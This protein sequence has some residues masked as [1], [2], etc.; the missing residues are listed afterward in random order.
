MCTYVYCTLH[1]S[2]PV[3]EWLLEDF[4]IGQLFATHGGQLMMLNFLETDF[5][6]WDVLHGTGIFTYWFNHK[7][8][9]K[10]VESPMESQK[11]WVFKLTDIFSAH[12]LKLRSLR[13]VLL[14]FSKIPV[15]FW[16]PLHFLLVVSCAKDEYFK[17]SGG[18]WT[19]KRGGGET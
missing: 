14:F 6:N 10:W 2:P 16:P 12:S 4:P 11:A 3:V 5:Q 19:S 8:H 17:Q 7:I 18:G 15:V 13:S 1:T 9:G